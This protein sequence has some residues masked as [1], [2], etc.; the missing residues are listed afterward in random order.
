METQ[1]VTVL[2][3][4]VDHSEYKNIDYNVIDR[5]QEFVKDNSI[6]SEFSYVSRKITTDE[7]IVEQMRVLDSMQFFIRQDIDNYDYF[8]NEIMIRAY[9]AGGYDV[10][11]QFKE[12]EAPTVD[13]PF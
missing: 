10:R 4:A 12:H 8:Q 2:H 13:L 7:G 6:Q 9:K 5:L 11:D 3:I 1:A